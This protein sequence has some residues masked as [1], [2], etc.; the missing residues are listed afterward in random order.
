[1]VR[2]RKTRQTTTPVKKNNRGAR[3]RT[4]DKDNTPWKFKAIVREPVLA[5]LRQYPIAENQSLNPITTKL[6]R[7]EAEIGITDDFVLWLK[8]CGPSIVVESPVKLRREI[9]NYA[10]DYARAYANKGP[11]LSKKEMVALKE[12]DRI[13]RNDRPRKTRT[14]HLFARKEISDYL[15]GKR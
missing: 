10:Y 13:L 12:M 1:M 5:I 8:R 15:R 11:L 9:E 6:A 7:I 4:L 2:K 14:L 3:R